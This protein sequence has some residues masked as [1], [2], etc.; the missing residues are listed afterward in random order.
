MGTDKVDFP[1]LIF[2]AP[3]LVYTSFQ[4]SPKVPIPCE[5]SHFWLS[6]ITYNAMRVKL[7]TFLGMDNYEYSEF[8]H[9]FHGKTNS[10]HIILK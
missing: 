3:A 7:A 10:F 8:L 1:W 6:H 4:K 5:S 9:D 2:L